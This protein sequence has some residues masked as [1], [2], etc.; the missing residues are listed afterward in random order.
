[1]NKAFI[2]DMDGVLINSEPVW[3]ELERTRL[4]KFFGADIFA[5]M[6]SFVGIGVSDVIERATSLGAVFEPAEYLKIANEMAQEVYA[7]SPVTR[8]VDVLAQKLLDMGFRLGLVTQSPQRWLNQVL[9]RLPFKDA[10]GIVIS[11][12]EHPELKRKPNPDG[13]L[14]AI[15]TL[16]AEPAHSIVL[17]DSNLGIASGKTAGAYVIGYRGNLPRG[18]EQE[19]AD[20]YADT[21]EDVIVLVERFI[22]Q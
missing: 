14:S 6:G 19:G 16:D 22:Q 2:F 21:M 10:L 18:Y 12:Y 5:R 1:M 7:R 17:E 20:A 13:Y 3:D 11:L 4:S 8:D 15:K 9:P